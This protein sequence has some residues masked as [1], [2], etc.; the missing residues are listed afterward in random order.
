MAVVT[1]IS[2]PNFAVIVE[3]APSN[4]HSA[5][6]GLA[7]SPETPDFSPV[8]AVMVGLLT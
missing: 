7:N 6:H 1:A 2:D 3:P 4:G 5:E 8:G